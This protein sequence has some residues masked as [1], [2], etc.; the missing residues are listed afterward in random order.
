MKSLVIATILVIFLLPLVAY[1]FDDPMEPDTLQILSTELAVG[2]SRPVYIRVFNDSMVYAISVGLSIETLDSGFAKFDSVV[3]M[4]RCASPLVLNERFVGVRDDDGI[5]PDQFFFFADRAFVGQQLPP[6]D[7]TLVAVYLTG[8]SAGQMYLDS[9]FYAPGGDFGFLTTEVIIG[10][11]P[12]YKPQFITPI[13]QV[14]DDLA[15]PV[16]STNSTIVSGY[17]G[18]SI[19]FDISAASQ[20]PLDGDIQMA[21][22][23]NYDDGTTTPATN[24]N[25]SGSNPVT[26]SWQPTLSDIGIWEARFTVCDT[27]GLCD[28]LDVTVQVV[29]SEDY[30]IDYTLQEYTDFIY[31]AEMSF[32]DFDQDMFPEIVA[33][34]IDFEGITS[35]GLYKY[36]P[37]TGFSQTYDAPDQQYKWGLAAGFIDSDS[38]LDFVTISSWPDGSLVKQIVLLMSGDGAGGFSANEQCNTASWVAPVGIS[39]GYFANGDNNL[40]LITSGINI[41]ASNTSTDFAYD[42]TL[43]PGA[44]VTSINGG[45]IN[46]DGKSDLIVGTDAGVKMYLGD[47]NSGFTLSDEFTQTYGTF[48]LE[49]TNQGSDFNDDGY[50][51]L[52]L[53]TPTST[54]THSEIVVYFGN[55]D[56]TFEQSVVRTP[57]GHVY[58]NRT[59]D[60]NG[61]GDLDIVY[62]N[63]SQKYLAVLFGEGDGTFTNEIRM[64]VEKYVPFRL[65]CLDIDLDGDNDIALSSQ[66]ASRGACL[67]LFENQLD[68]SEMEQVPV[69]IDAVNNVDLTLISESGKELRKHKNTMASAALYQ[70]DLDGN[71]TIDDYATLGVVE[72]GEYLIDAVPQPGAIAGDPFTLEFDIAG[73]L[74]RFVKDYPMSQSGYQFA[75]FPAGFATV[76]PAPGSFIVTNPP[77]LSWYGVGSDYDLQ[78]ADNP[79]FDS[80][81]VAITV[82]ANSY[83]IGEALALSDTATYY[84]R[85]KSTGAIEYSPI[86]TF[87]LVAASGGD[88][89]VGIRGN[90]NSDPGETV[91]I[92]DVTFLVDYLFGIP[93]GTAPR[94]AEEANV[95]GDPDEKLN[96][97]DLTY[98]VQYLFGVPAGAAP[99]NCP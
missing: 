45:D 76:A 14:V 8:L 84:W 16:L 63:G 83:A 20:V 37:G 89:C 47:G 3:F 44:V 65:S 46:N 33:S 17:V 93:Q 5:P 91:N 99:S 61:D 54:G 11:D 48:D 10:E 24:P 15:P 98:L 97:T 2:Q 80:P 96:I 53:A 39:L 57:L 9:S 40:D 36:E 35:I 74:Y 68:P 50:Y 19:S 28:T 51:D 13:L 27:L 6:G 85:I 94:C 88:C 4:G 23:V 95:N 90:V 42:A 70:R 29:A 60:I 71:P 12:I 26:I 55:G 87:N 56:G 38:Y 69:A 31:T 30:L 79:D 67:Y 22:L 82:A 41:Y 21:G 64:P 92:S 58:A 75:V 77:L 86:Y 7:D 73:Q 43:N 62:A 49:I 52:C 34:G 18:G 78:L 66:E 81:I 25:L 59:S 72:R 1:G 32:G